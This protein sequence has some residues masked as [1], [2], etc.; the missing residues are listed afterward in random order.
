MSS[1]PV[2]CSQCAVISRGIVGNCKHVQAITNELK[3]MERVLRHLLPHTY[4]HA[5]WCGYGRD[6]GPNCQCDSKERLASI[7]ALPTK[8]RKLSGMDL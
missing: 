3:A 7:K 4:N 5:S 1:K 2:V 8:L 6:T